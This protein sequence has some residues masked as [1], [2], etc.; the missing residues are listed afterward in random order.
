MRL[1]N[2]TLSPTRINNA[3]A[4]DKLYKLTDGGGLFVELSAAGLKTW[5]YQCLRVGQSFG[6]G[7]WH[8][9]QRGGVAAIGIARD[10]QVA[11]QIGLLARWR[12]GDDGLAIG[13][14]L[15]GYLHLG[16]LATRDNP[17]QAPK[18]DDFRLS[19]HSSTVLRH[20]QRPTRSHRGP[21]SRRHAQGKM[22]I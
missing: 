13:D 1:S 2:Y 21:C 12:G 17:Q 10:S 11:L 6:M 20:P 4:K 19:C 7:R 3:K 9:G 8:N 22:G 14:L 5:R 16:E 18:K 15:F